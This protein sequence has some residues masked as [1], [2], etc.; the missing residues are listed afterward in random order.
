MA[1]PGNDMQIK[2]HRFLSIPIEQEA[3]YLLGQLNMVDER[4]ISVPIGN[5]TQSSRLQADTV[6]TV[7]PHL[8]KEDIRKS[9]GIIL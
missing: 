1:T 6:I 8:R 3:G 2:H 9:L 4:K 5:Q 7:T